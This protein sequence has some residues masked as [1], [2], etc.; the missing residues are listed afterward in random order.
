MYY[1]VWSWVPLTEG[2]HVLFVRATDAIGRTADS[3]AVHIQASAAAGLIAV[4]TAKGG[5][6]LQSLASQNGL[7]PQQMGRQSVLAG[8]ALERLSTF[9]RQHRDQT[10]RGGSLD[11]HGI[12]SGR[13]ANCIGGTHKQDMSTFR[14]RD[15]G[16][17]FIVHRKPAR[18]CLGVKKPAITPELH[19]FNHSSGGNHDSYRYWRINRPGAAIHRVV[20]YNQER[21]RVGGEL[22]RGRR[23][24][25]D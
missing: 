2:A 19:A 18:R 25:C 13:A 16:P 8:K 21:G 1:K 14:Q 12:R 10:S 4:L 23:D 6:T 11:V 22:L 9:G 17:D 5:E 24:S 20:Q 7:T 15:P 3:N